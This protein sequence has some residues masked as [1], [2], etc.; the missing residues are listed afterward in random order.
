LLYLKVDAEIEALE[1]MASVKVTEGTTTMELEDKSSRC[2]KPV[3]DRCNRKAA[4]TRRMRTLAEEEAAGTVEIKDKAKLTLRRPVDDDTS[5]DAKIGKKCADRAKKDIEDIAAEAKADIAKETDAGKKKQRAKKTLADAEDVLDDELELNGDL[6][7]KAGDKVSK[8]ARKAKKAAKRAAR[9][10]GRKMLKA[11]GVTGFEDAAGDE[12]RAEVEQKLDIKKG[13]EVEIDG[14]GDGKIR[15]K[16][17]VSVEVGGE[18]TVKPEKRDKTKSPSADATKFAACRKAKGTDCAK[19]AG[20]V[21]DF[22]A[23]VENKGEIAINYPTGMTD[24]EIPVPITRKCGTA[25]DTGKVRANFTRRMVHKSRGLARRPPLGL[26]LLAACL[27]LGIGSVPVASALTIMQTHLEPFWTNNVN[28]FF[29][30]AANT[31]MSVFF[32]A[33]STLAVGDAVAV[34]LPGWSTKGRAGTDFDFQ[35]S[36]ADNDITSFLLYR[37]QWIGGA[38]CVLDDNFHIYTCPNAASA[39][40]RY[41]QPFGDPAGAVSNKWTCADAT[42]CGKWDQASRTLTL[43]VKR[44]LPAGRWGGFR[45]A[46]SLSVPAA[47]ITSS[48]S[49]ASITITSASSGSGTKLL[50]A[51]PVAKTVF[52]LSFQPAQPGVNTA[53]TWTI[54]CNEDIPAGRRIV[55]SDVYFSGMYVCSTVCVRVC[56]RVYVCVRVRLYVYVW[57]E[58]RP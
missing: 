39:A 5:D 53:A 7:A 12:K 6:E 2:A 56:V 41:D 24:D 42:S 25:K 55:I 17:K 29:P 16:G 49:G 45:F 43:K 13:A 19:K 58:W 23:G 34:S 3:R 11:E 22:D 35:S 57:E 48:G 10:E 20:S 52:A 44:A 50:A 14:V 37:G 1:K 18:V 9:K 8:A 21:A 27:L 47:G 32:K 31:G 51:H 36:T 26:G 15:V 40:V 33:S 28:P 46:A 54:K 30:E 38:D 4:T